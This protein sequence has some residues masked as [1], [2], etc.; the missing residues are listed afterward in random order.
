VAFQKATGKPV[1]VFDVSN[2]PISG[3]GKG[4]DPEGDTLKNLRDCAG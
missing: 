2:D 1:G 3:L 4:R